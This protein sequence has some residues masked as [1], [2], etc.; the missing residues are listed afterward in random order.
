[1]EQGLGKAN[2]VRVIIFGGADSRLLGPGDDRVLVALS[3]C[4]QSRGDIPIVIGRRILV[5]SILAAGDHGS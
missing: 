5:T 4:V 2:E 1:M 3:P